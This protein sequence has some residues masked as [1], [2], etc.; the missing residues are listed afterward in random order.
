MARRKRLNKR[1]VVLLVVLGVI[2]MAGMAAF[3]IRKLPKNPVAYAAKGEAAFNAE[4]YGQAER[5]YSVAINYSNDEPE[6][7]EYYYRLALVIQKQLTTNK[8]L[9]VSER[10]EKL[11]RILAYLTQATLL[12]PEHVDAQ[13]VLCD[14]YFSF[15]FAG[16]WKRYLEH[17]DKLLKLVPDD[18]EIYYRRGVVKSELAKSLPLEWTEGAASDLRKAIE[19]KGDEAMYRL[20]LTSLLERTQR[21]AE[22]QEAYAEAIEANPDSAAIRIGHAGFLDRRGQNDEALKELQEAASR[23]PN[24]SDGLVAMARF[25]MRKDN[26]DQAEAALKSALAIDDSDYLVYQRFADLYRRKEKTRKSAEVLRQG[27]AAI[28]RRVEQADPNVDERSIESGQLQMATIQLNYVLAATLLD[29]VEGNSVQDKEQLLEEASVCLRRIA[30]MPDAQQYNQ[31]LSARIAL[32]QGRLDDAQN[33]LEDAYETFFRNVRQGTPPSDL[34]VPS[35]LIRL[36]LR[37]GWPGEAEKVANEI[38]KIPG[39]ERHSG[40][41]LMKADMAMRYRDFDEA[42]KLVDQVLR[43]DSTNSRAMALKHQLDIITG[44]VSVAKEGDQV[45]PRTIALSIDQARTAWSRG[46]RDEA[47]ARLEMLLALTS[48]NDRVVSQLTQMYVSLGRPDQA[49]ALLNRVLEAHPERVK[50][51]ELLI[52]LVDEPD[53]EKRFSLSMT[54]VD[55]T[56]DPFR[57]ALER[58]HICATHG[59]KD[60][61]AK[62]LREAWNITPNSGYAAEVLFASALSEKNWDMANECVDKVRKENIDRVGGRLFAARLA[63]A[64]SRYTDAIPLLVEALEE[65]KDSKYA[66]VLLGQCYFA[67]NNLDRAEDEFLTVY[68]R[69]P[70]YEAAVLGLAR[71]T[72]RTGDQSGHAK[73]I[74]RGHRLAPNNA[75]IHSRYLGF[76]ETKAKA[77]DLPK[78]IAERERILKRMPNDLMNRYYL[79]NLYHRT[80]QLIKAEQMYVYLYKTSNDKLAVTRLLINFYQKENRL[81]DVDRIMSQVLKITDDKVGA[82]VMYGRF[83]AQYNTGQARAAM[84]KAIQ[85]DPND[86]RGYLALAIFEGDLRNWSPAID[87]LKKFLSLR[88]DSLVHEKRLINWLVNAKQLDEAAKHVDRILSADPSDAEALTLKG[89]VELARNNRTRAKDLFNRAMQ[90]NPNYVAP[91]MY[92]GRLARARG[93]L[94]QC[95]M[96]L[97]KANDLS[98][99]PEVTRDLAV[100]Y[101]QLKDYRKAQLAYED[102][103]LRDPQY[104]PAIRGLIRL[105]FIRKDWRSLETLLADAMSFFPKDPFYA[106]IKGKM[107]EAMGDE[108]KALGSLRL[109]TEK[110]A[111]LKNAG[112]SYLAEYV[113]ALRKSDKDNELLALSQRYADHEQFAVIAQAASATVLAKRGDQDEADTMFISAFKA[114]NESQ[115]LAFVTV[116]I[117]LS[118]GLEAARKKVAAWGEKYRANDWRVCGLLGEWSASAGDASGA[119]TLLLK[120]QRLAVKTADKVRAQIILGDFYSKEK[121]LSESE[122]AYKKALEIDPNDTM[123]ANNLAYL[124]VAK[125]NDPAKAL[126]FAITAAE[127]LPNNAD[128]L[129]TYGWTLAKLKRYEDALQY[130]RESVQLDDT[131]VAN[132]F[133]LGWTLEQTGRLTD[134]MREYRK[135]LD[136]VGGDSSN[137]FYLDLKNAE[138]RIGE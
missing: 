36:Y 105:H 118:Y 87:A 122:R 135:G 104:V 110:A 89:G 95:V 79:A 106:M 88:G 43:R 61:Q 28:D 30:A 35:L 32:N 111:R 90:E 109:A 33:L 27:L 137:E 49:K 52:S 46:N 67:T 2:L 124:Y 9:A 68:D 103:L 112:T 48:N 63:V 126:P 66:R 108:D 85:E 8:T 72:E 1:V 31:T 13:R 102:L 70:S 86:E 21:L 78:L 10:R 69:D 15:A 77:E 98:Y 51:L 125:L 97:E 7:P 101:I 59:K 117:Q 57:K 44:S 39:Y 29:I 41:L 75:Y 42:R 65:L 58:A 100:A 99:L 18:H 123:V 11:R 94:T 50:K 130:L 73:W 93:D 80:G 6:Q 116:Q 121:R 22:A 45:S 129:D 5:Y 25:Y 92:L 134:A 24:N 37:K 20:S 38:L 12:D 113:V 60:E 82:Y 74:E 23:E 56:E 3:I 54:E 119:E 127:T 114:A 53:L 131:Q 62:Y 16:E 120:A 128:V 136:I 26:F 34:V 107:H 84:N 55:K 133:H 14:V 132:R 76:R 4:N 138:K 19:L 96:Y 81:G 64:Q 83:L 71:V 40:A 47:I 17:A 115:D 91:L